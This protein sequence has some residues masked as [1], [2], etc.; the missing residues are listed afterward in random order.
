MNSRPVSIGHILPIIVMAMALTGC[1]P[2][3]DYEAAKLLVDI[4]AGAKEAPSGD[5]AEPRRLARNFQVKGVRYHADLYLA[6]QKPLAAML[7]LPG[8]A[9][10][11]KDDPRLQALAMSMA[12]ARFAVLVPDLQGFRSLQIGS[13]DTEDVTRCFY[14]LATQQDLAPNGRAGLCGIS[15]ACGPAVLA[16]LDP[17]IAQRVRFIMTIG[18][19]YD[20]VRV[21]T[22]FTTGYFQKEGTWQYREPNHYGKWVF[23]LSNIRRLSLA[24]DRQLF[25]RMAARKLDDPGAAVG[26]LADGLSPEGRNF[27]N[28]I[29]N[30]DRTRVTALI[31]RLPLSIRQEITRLNIAGYDMGRLKAQMIIL[32]GYDDDII[33]YTESVALAENISRGQG[34]LYLVQGL[35]HVNLKPRIS[36]TIKLWRALSRLLRVSRQ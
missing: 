22:F 14:W 1:N 15:Y 26:D 30:R 8:A 2:V 34:S 23:V 6:G 7:L 36:D 32:H 18:G 16:A 10:K 20:L 12:R 13:R 27:F 24:T 19:Y 33:P 11:G 3:R 25:A 5:A 4:A 17:L 9:E 35:M 21:L 28:F 31:G 29:E